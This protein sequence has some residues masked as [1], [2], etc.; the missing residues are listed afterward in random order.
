MVTLSC[1]PDVDNLCSDFGSHRTAAHPV[2]A[3][4]PTEPNDD[5]AH[6]SVNERIEA[7]GELTRQ[8]LAWNR[9]PRDEPD[10]RDLL[11]AF[12]ARGVE[13]IVVGAHALAAHGLVRATKDLDVWVRPEIGRSVLSARHLT[14]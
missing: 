7:V 2:V 11:A 12:N 13:F 6:A 4:P 8:C 5:W 10:F 3:S 1:S 9:D 14:E